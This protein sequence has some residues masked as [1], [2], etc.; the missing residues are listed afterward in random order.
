IAVPRRWRPSRSTS[1]RSTASTR[2]RYCRSRN[3]GGD[4]LLR[5]P[6]LALLPRVWLIPSWGGT[7]DTRHERHELRPLG[8]RLHATGAVIGYQGEAIE[9][10]QA[11]ACESVTQY[12]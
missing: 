5:R 12:R 1:S 8:D 11:V 4:G 9:I 7:A 10:G 3:S 6:N 2:V